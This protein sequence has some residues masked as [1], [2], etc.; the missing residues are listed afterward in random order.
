VQGLGLEPRGERVSFIPAVSLVR[1]RTERSSYG[2]DVAASWTA[3]AVA[4][5]SVIVHRRRQ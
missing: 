1:G 5:I 4:S 2:E 3:F